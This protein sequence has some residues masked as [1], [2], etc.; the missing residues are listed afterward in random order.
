MHNSLGED[1]KKLKWHM[2]GS[3][4]KNKINKALKIFDCFQT[5]DSV[6]LAEA[7]NK[8]AEKMDKII[9]VFIEVNIGSEIT[10]SGL[11]P[12]YEVIKKVVMEVSKRRY[13]KM[14]GLMTMGP[15][16]GDPENVRIYFRKTKEIFDKLKDSGISNVNL[17]YLSMGMSNSYKVAIEEGANMV[18][19]GTAV[20]G[21]RECELE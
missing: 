7:L 13:I 9:S 8:R 3:L 17:K 18:R 20:F 12:D 14:E 15:R 11:K 10:K 4:Q 16:V 2:I 21:K 1:A 19:L 6:E 5:I